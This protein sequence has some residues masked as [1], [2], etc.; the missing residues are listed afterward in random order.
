MSKRQASLVKK[1]NLV[2]GKATMISHMDQSYPVENDQVFLTDKQ[3]APF[4]VSGAIMLVR[5]QVSET[6]QPGLLPEE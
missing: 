3:A 6:A 4:L 1:Y 5:E 2:S